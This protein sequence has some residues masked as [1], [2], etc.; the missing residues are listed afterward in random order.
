MGSSYHNNASIILI[1]NIIISTITII[2]I[3]NIIVIT[4][5]VI[6]IISSFEAAG[7]QGQYL[8]LGLVLELLCRHRIGEGEQAVREHRVEVRWPGGDEM[9]QRGPTKPKATGNLGP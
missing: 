3:M 2:I 1:I 6:I 5:I 4:I 8:P 7:L 9:Q